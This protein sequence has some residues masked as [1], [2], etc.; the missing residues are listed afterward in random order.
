MKRIVLCLLLGCLLFKGYSQIEIQ[1]KIESGYLL[2]QFESIQID[3][4]PNWKGYHLNDEQNGVDV[5]FIYGAKIKDRFLPSIGLGYLNFEGIHGF[6]IFSEFE[7]SIFKT[8]FTP[9]INLRL[10]YNHI[11]NQ[12]E[13]GTGSAL[14]EF[15]GGI[16]YSFNEKIGI[17][18]KSGLLITQQAFIIPVRLG[19]S[20]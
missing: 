7:Y 18:L 8:K 1:K 4:G 2:Y 10:G 16:K 9:L 19:I 11:W 14:G 17:Y 13:N 12:Y 5:N 20:F 3:P 15:G 6:S